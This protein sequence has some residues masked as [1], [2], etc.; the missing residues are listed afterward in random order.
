VNGKGKE[1][2]GSGE[3]GKGERAALPLPVPASFLGRF[4]R[5]VSVSVL[6]FIRPFWF[7]FRSGL[8]LQVSFP[9]RSCFVSVAAS[10]PLFRLVSFPFPSV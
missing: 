8:V 10:V 9:F 1:K 3:R 5:F 4:P 7:R 2:Q 6:G